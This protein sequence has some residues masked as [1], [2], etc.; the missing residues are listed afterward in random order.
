M[1]CSTDHENSV[2]RG[3]HGDSLKET[4]VPALSLRIVS[5]Y[6]WGEHTF[7]NKIIT[8]TRCSTLKECIL[9]RSYFHIII[10]ITSM[11]GLM[12]VLWFT[13]EVWETKLALQESR[14]QALASG[15][16]QGLLGLTCPARTRRRTLPA[17]CSQVRTG[18]RGHRSPC[19]GLRFWCRCWE[20]LVLGTRRDPRL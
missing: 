6:V 7:W 10:K 12:W 17:G 8:K 18:R 11:H 13:N 19:T 16:G 2:Q 15:A 9:I 4:S 5:A 20:G 14:C 1:I 3:C